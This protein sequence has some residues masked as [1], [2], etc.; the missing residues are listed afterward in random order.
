MRLIKLHRVLVV[1]GAALVTSCGNADDSQS[2]TV[3]N[4]TDAAP[5]DD[6]AEL[7]NDAAPKTD[8][9]GVDA[10][11]SWVTTDPP[12]TTS[13][14]RTPLEDAADATEGD[15]GSAADASPQDARGVDAWLS[16]A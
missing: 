8:G 3:T 12:V 9:K 6:G 2:Q 15:A 11:L 16:W 13:D 4:L 14:A 1:G 7:S 5:N 10:W